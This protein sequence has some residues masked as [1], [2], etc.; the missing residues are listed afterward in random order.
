ME[1][2]KQNRNLRE[3]AAVLQVSLFREVLQGDSTKNEMN[4]LEK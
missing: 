2:L 3:H 1:F 4:L